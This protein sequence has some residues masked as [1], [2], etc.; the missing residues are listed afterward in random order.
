[1][2]LID[3]RYFNEC[4]HPDDLQRRRLAE[5]LNLKPKQI[6]FWFQNKRTQVKIQNEKAENAELR[7]DNLKMKCENEAMEEALKTVVCP[8]CGGRH[9]GR[10]EQLLYLQNLRAENAFLEIERERLSSY[11][12][13][14]RGHS[15]RSVDALPYLHGPSTFNNRPASYGT[16]Y[17]HLPT[18]SSLLRGPYT[19]ENI[20]V[21]PQP[22]PQ[23]SVLL[24]HLQ[25]LSQPEKTVMFEM[26]AKAVAEVMSLSKMEESVWIKS[27]ID[28]RLVIDPGNYE[29]I[30]TKINHFKS[31][32]V[33]PESSKEVVV[34]QMDATNLVDMFFDTEKWA[35]LF[36]TIVNEAKT[37]HVL[38]SID[39]GRQTFSKV[40][41]EQEHILSPLVPPRQFII[42]RS[43]QQV[44]EDLWMIA[45][46]SCHLPNVELDFTAPLCTKRPSGVLIQALPHGGSKVTWIEHVEVNDNVRPHRLYKDLLYS[47]F[48]YGA[49]RWTVTLERM[50]E[51]LSLYSMS[52]FPSTD[53]AG[54]VKTIEG[55]R[56]V[57]NLGER[58]LKNFAWI[59]KMSDKH[60][61]SQQCDTN[62]S[63]V[64]ISVR[65]NI[66]AGQPT[67]L[68]VC[69][70]SSLY[71]PLTPLRVYDFL[72]NLEVRH[73]WDVLCHGN[74]ATEAAR[75]V[76]GSNQK[77]NVTFLKPSSGGENS[78]LMILQDGFI[79]AL[80]GMFVYAPVDLN[81]AY[82]AISGQV[83]PSTIPVLPSGFIISRDSRPSVGELDSERM[84]LLTVAF[85][86]LVSGSS[87]S[88]NLNLE[89]SATTVHI[90]ISSTVQRVK[91]MLNCE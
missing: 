42:L 54:V 53:H 39:H 80:G 33:R 22:K 61:F 20:N 65:T 62:N 82:S 67:G 38:D 90:L 66:E 86:I 36:P 37:L 91:A 75:F 29:K 81:T 34:V 7:I 78:E 73:Q 9:P 14:H 4:P 72:S 77:N 57:M 56:S 16:S 58:M 13:Q 17:N 70:S 23:N 18:Q 45:D 24:Q 63:G 79:D 51:R 84:T 68:I 87:Q 69:A 47:G 60:D 19:R 88:T 50:C 21:T 43:C 49:R 55:R 83:D 3:L 6:K 44:E 48:G 2:L 27:S 74:P 25:A 46:V 15:I 41:Y 71:L 5:E 89:D 59:M 52:D 85:Q 30:S 40:I 10:K 1:I 12:S 31:T 11:V 64:R 26:A 35:R 8:P 76:T 28:G 32:S